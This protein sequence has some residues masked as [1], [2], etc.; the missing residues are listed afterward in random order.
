MTFPI[1]LSPISFLSS[2]GRVSLSMW[3]RAA[4]TAMTAP[5]CAENISHGSDHR[6]RFL[7]VTLP[8]NTPR[9]IPLSSD[10]VPARGAKVCR[11]RHGAGSV[12]FAFSGIFSPDNRAEILS[13]PLILLPWEVRNLFPIRG[14]LPREVWQ[15]DWWL[16]YETARQ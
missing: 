11:Y 2:R 10:T 6:F 12:S 15:C 3:N 4:G 16:H 7:P 13:F 9:I 5:L 14:I 8:S 1:I